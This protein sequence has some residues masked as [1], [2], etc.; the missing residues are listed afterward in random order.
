MITCAPRSGPLRCALC[1]DALDARVDARVVVCRSCGAAHHQVC[2]R[3]PARCATCS[4]RLVVRW[5]PPTTARPLASVAAALASAALAVLSV[6]AGANLLPGASARAAP[7]QVVLA[8]ADPARARPADDD[9][10]DASSEDFD[11]RRWLRPRVGHAPCGG[12]SLACAYDGCRYW[13]DR[14]ER[15]A[16]EAALFEA[17][18]ALAWALPRRPRGP[19]DVELAAVILRGFAR[20]AQ[21]HRFAR[22]DAWRALARRSLTCLQ[23]ARLADGSFPV[24]P[25]AQVQAAGA[26]VAL[27]QVGLARDP[28]LGRRDVLV[29]Q[30]YALA[31]T[32][33][34]RWAPPRTWREVALSAHPRLHLD[35]ARE[36]VRALLRTLVATRHADGTWDRVAEEWTPERPEL[37][38]AINALLLACALFEPD[39]TLPRDRE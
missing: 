30:A 6:G 11:E 16:A 22:R 1:H 18:N 19:A 8:G 38:T 24:P 21:S 34:E 28:C 32:P 14:S 15:H 7:V 10:D 9:D 29:A 12:C 33:V 26:F 3:I 2:S 20:T 31:R 5:R 35:P 39:G 17:W 13:R 27:D 23:Q 4:A 36:D 37:A 25:A